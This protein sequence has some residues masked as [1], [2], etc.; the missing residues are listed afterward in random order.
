[1]TCFEADLLVWLQ[2]RWCDAANWRAS[3]PTRVVAFDVYLP[4][5]SQTPNTT[6]L[7]GTGVLDALKSRQT[8]VDS[9]DE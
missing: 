4:T 7:A 3:R 8:S 1:M 2:P 6:F 9:S 5:F